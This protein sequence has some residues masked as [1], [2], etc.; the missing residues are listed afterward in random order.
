MMS[1]D[2]Q[3]GSAKTLQ[4]YKMKFSMADIER[5]NKEKALKGRVKKFQRIKKDIMNDIYGC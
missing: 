1:T 3:K 2:R 4:I 5:A